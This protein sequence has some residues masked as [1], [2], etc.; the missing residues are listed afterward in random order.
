MPLGTKAYKN[1]A[2]KGLNTLG[3]NKNNLIKS[4]KFKFSPESDT[5]NSGDIG[6]SVGGFGLKGGM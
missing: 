3:A 1:F 5:N 6:L 2:P 4:D